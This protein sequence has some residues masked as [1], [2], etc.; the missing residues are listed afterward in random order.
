[1][2]KAKKKV[3]VV[4][5]YRLGEQNSVIDILQ[6]DGRIVQKDDGSYE[7]FSRESGSGHGEKAQPGDYVKIDSSGCPYPNSAAFFE[8]NHR[9]IEGEYYEQRQKALSVW[10]SDDPMCPEVE[11]LEKNKG[12]VLDPDHPDRYFSAPLWGTNLTA[13]KDAALVFY[14]IDRD[15]TGKVCDAEFNF[16]ARDEFDKTYELLSENQ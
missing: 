7:V 12:L 14:R 16:V 10:F 13:G 9:H 4:K 11:F 1:M 8:K 6:K 3:S 15:E 5:A 2:R